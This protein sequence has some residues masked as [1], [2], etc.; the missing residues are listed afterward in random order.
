MFL[1]WFFLYLCSITCTTLGG[2]GSNL[3]VIANVL[4]QNSSVMYADLKF[5]LL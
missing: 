3:N 2:E 4:N 1:I 5:H